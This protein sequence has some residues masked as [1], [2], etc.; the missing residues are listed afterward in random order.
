MI[1]GHRTL[2]NDEREIVFNWT[3]PCTN[4]GSLDSFEWTRAETEDDIMKEV[5]F[6]QTCRKTIVDWVSD[7][8]DNEDIIC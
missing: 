8:D 1:I 3:F 5:L 2:Q 4:E 7:D 6:D